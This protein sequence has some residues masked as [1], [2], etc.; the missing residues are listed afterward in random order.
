MECVT[1]EY[2]Y[3]KTEV[4]ID[5]YDDKTIEVF[6]NGSCGTLARALYRIAGL[7]VVLTNGHAAVIAPNG[8]ILD[9]QGVHTVSNF[10]NEWG[11][12]TDIIMHPQLEKVM[13]HDWGS[14]DW[15]SAIPIAI[16]LIKNYKKEAGF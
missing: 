5:V 12:I 7:P 9:I 14:D 8:K 13:R 6:T 1:I 4:P 10:E 3:R 15:K 2:Q 16:K 11:N